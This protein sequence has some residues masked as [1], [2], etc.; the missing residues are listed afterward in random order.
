[1]QFSNIHSSQA[2]KQDRVPYV[3]QRNEKSYYGT[4][5][6]M[7]AMFQNLLCA[8]TKSEYRLQRIYLIFAKSD[9]DSRW[10]QL[11]HHAAPD[12][13]GS[14]FAAV[15]DGPVQL[16]SKVQCFLSARDE[17]SVEKKSSGKGED[18]YI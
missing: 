13:L 10:V 14:P 17:C 12:V 16:G 9:A 5:R 1:M 2:Y 15:R 18:P 7:D 8:Y 3:K 6:L 4:V 11:L